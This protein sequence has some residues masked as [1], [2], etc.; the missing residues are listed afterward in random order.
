VGL[1]T[2]FRRF[3]MHRTKLKELTHEVHSLTSRGC[4]NEALIKVA[5]SVSML[6]AVKLLSLID[7]IQTLENH[8]LPRSLEMY[9]NSLKLRLLERLKQDHGD[10]TYKAVLK[11]LST[12]N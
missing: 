4:L 3:N 11:A 7:T 5:C 1:L 2:S 6:Q 10:D 8:Q 9:R 12:N